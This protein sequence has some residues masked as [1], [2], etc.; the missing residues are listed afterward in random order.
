MIRALLTLILLG[1]VGYLGYWLFKT[2]EEPISFN[3]EKTIRTASTVEKLKTIRSAE[4]AYRNTN[5]SYAGTPEELKNFIKTGDYLIFTKIG[6]PNDSTSIVRVD[7]SRVPILDSLFKGNTAQV[8]SLFIAPHTGGQK[9]QLEAGNI[10][11][12][13]TEIPAFEA[14]IQYQNLYSGLLEKY[15]A[16]KKNDFLSVGS[17]ENGTTTGNWE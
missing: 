6:D 8:D 13:D 10:V 15:Y 3:A 4:I 16:N 2:V 9:I 14:K 12:N 17:M 11:K 7:T 1:V 5:G